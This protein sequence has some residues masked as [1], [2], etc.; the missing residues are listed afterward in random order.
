MKTFKRVFWAK[1]L[2]IDE[3]M[4]WEVKNLCDVMNAILYG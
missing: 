4:P 3:V 1:K 2:S